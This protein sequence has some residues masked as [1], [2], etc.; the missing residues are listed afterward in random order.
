MKKIK[1][2]YETEISC[3][4]KLKLPYESKCTNFHGHNYKIE[5]VIKGIETNL[6]KEAMLID[7]TK[8][9]SITHKYDHKTLNDYIEQ[10]TAENLAK[11]LVDDIKSDLD[12]D[13][14]V[15]VKVWEDSGSYAEV[16]E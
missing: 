4:H 2:Y 6:N 5:I 1:L 8:L 11:V 14:I 13:I 3:A 16:T 7:F 9:K 10:P 12:K 15:S